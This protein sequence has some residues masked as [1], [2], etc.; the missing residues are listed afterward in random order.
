MQ[1]LVFIICIVAALAVRV[2]CVRSAE[3]FRRI[4]R[5]TR[6][7]WS[8]ASGSV[9]ATVIHTFVLLICFFLIGLSLFI[10]Y[11]CVFVFFSVVGADVPKDRGHIHKGCR[12]IKTRLVIVL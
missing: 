1:L 5:N 7:H 8:D 6:V 9:T 4:R 3:H 2:P 12:K 11:F 10:V